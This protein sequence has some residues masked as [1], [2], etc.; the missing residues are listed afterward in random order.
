MTD[1]R[2][3]DTAPKGPVPQHL[4]GGI[5]SGQ[6]LIRCQE[7]TRIYGD[8]EL[9]YALDHVTF[10][11]KEGEMLAVMGPSGSGKSTLLNMLGALDKPTSGTVFIDGQDLS[12]VK[13]VDRFRARTVGF[14]FQMHNLIPTLSALENVEVP[15]RGQGL[16]ASKQRARAQELL[17][18][19]GLADRVKH[20]PAQLSGGQRQR[21]AIARALANEPPLVLADEPT[22]N[23]DSVSSIELIALLDRLNRERGTTILIVTHDHRVATATRRI[24]HMSDGKIVDEHIVGDPLTEDL[25]DLARSELGQRLIVGDLQALSALPLVREGRFTQTAQQLAALLAEL[26]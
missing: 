1:G 19:V 26:A 12:K 22:G 24:L 2:K 23:L 21:V 5:G 13:N 6:T 11:V 9:I 16:S 17:A 4:E 10:T 18:L 3:P 8:G 7:L 15:M 20:L 25:R 14:V